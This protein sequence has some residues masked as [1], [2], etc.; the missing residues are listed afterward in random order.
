M[1]TIFIYFSGSNGPNVNKKIEHLMN[2]EILTDR[3]KPLLSI[4][5]CNIHTLHNGFLKG[6]E[7][8]GQDTSEFIIAIYYFF[9]GWPV[10]LED[11][12]KIQQ[13]LG[14]PTHRFIKHVTSRWLT[15]QIG[16]LNNGLQLRII[17]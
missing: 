10:R 17:S 2:D 16:L 12:E 9:K 4:G 5:F 8:F 1:S 11:F 7:E 14:L 3:K 15:P 6:V 13:E